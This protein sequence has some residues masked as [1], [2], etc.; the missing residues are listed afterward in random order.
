MGGMF[1]ERTGLSGPTQGLTAGF[2]EERCNLQ[3]LGIRKRTF[4]GAVNAAGHT[5]SALTVGPMWV[6][7]K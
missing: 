7:V 6:G 1:R 3:K 4:G 2:S 5:A